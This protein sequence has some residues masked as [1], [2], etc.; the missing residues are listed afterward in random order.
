MDIPMELAQ[1]WV[2]LGI[3]KDDKYKDIPHVLKFF[4]D[5]CA[6]ADAVE[7]CKFASAWRFGIGPTR[8]ANLITA[9]TGI[10]YNWEDI[11]QAGERIYAVEYAMQRRFGLGRESD[12]PPLRFFEEK[13][14]QGHILN[15]EKYEA[16]LSQYYQIRGYDQNGVPTE[17]KLKA[18]GLEDVADDMKKRKVAECLAAR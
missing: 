12:Q 1:K 18:L 5:Q 8:M 11:L 17:K 6:A 16:A 7:I 10:K 3:A 2:K 15:K 14:Q 9:A 4:Q 13:S